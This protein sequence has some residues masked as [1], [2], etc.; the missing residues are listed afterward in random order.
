MLAKNIRGDGPCAD[1]KTEENP[2]WFTDNVFWN[3]TM[4]KERGK[5]LCINCFISRAY[6]KYKGIVSW[7]VLPCCQW[8]PNQKWSKL[9]GLHEKII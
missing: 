2:I 6:C 1:C 9:T 8:K 3:E 5:I 7:R 4:V